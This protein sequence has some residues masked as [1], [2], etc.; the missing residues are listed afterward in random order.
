MKVWPQSNFKIL[1]IWINSEWKKKNHRLLQE[2]GKVFK[3]VS[4]LAFLINVW[5][6]LL[7]FGKFANQEAIVL[8]IFGSDIETEH[9][10][11]IDY[12]G[13]TPNIVFYIGIFT[14]N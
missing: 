3:M 5:G 8:V 1:L 6:R 4:T 2:K 11:H 13:K 10:Q 12:C 7:I 14:L 9:V